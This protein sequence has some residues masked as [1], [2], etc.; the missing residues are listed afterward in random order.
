[1]ISTKS[2]PLRKTRV[3]KVS[4][5]MKMRLSTKMIKPLDPRV[6]KNLVKSSKGKTKMKMSMMMRINTKLKV[7][8]S[9]TSMDPKSKFHSETTKKPSSK[10]VKIGTPSS[11]SQQ[12]SV[13]P[14][15]PLPPCTTIFPTHKR[16]K[17]CSLPI[18]SNLL[19]SKLKPSK[20]LFMESFRT[21][22]SAKNSTK[23]TEEIK[24]ISTGPGTESAD[25]LC[26]FTV[27]KI[28]KS[29]KQKRRKSKAALCRKRSSLENF[30]T[31]PLSL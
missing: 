22:L 3:M 15:L 27:K 21:N 23:N 13:K 17:L 16:K 14:V 30:K 4:L 5:S 18:L 28:R 2:F 10:K 26:V 1:M 19:N 25:K 12:V 9:K 6:R 7:Q 11:T 20:G 24:F 31:P 8:K 29:G